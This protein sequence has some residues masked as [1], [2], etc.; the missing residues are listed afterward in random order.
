[1]GELFSDLG[2]TLNNFWKGKKKDG[3]PL[4]NLPEWMTKPM[5]ELES[6]VI[7]QGT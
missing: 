4:F 6:L 3:T 7:K 2:A 5:G 1:M